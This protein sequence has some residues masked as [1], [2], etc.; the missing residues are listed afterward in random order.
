MNE[1]VSKCLLAGDKVL[2]EMHLRQPGFTYS[3]LRPFAKNRRNTKVQRN[4]KSKIYLSKRARKSLLLAWYGLIWL[5]V[6][7]QDLPAPDKICD[8]VFNIAKNPK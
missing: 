4:S 1:I 8:Q 5:M 2:P 3:A 6:T 7:Y